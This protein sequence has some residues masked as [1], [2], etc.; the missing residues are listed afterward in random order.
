M[1]SKP[2]RIQTKKESKN[3][4]MTNWAIKTENEPINK[5]ILIIPCTFT[6]HMF[7]WNESTAYLTAIT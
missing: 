7:R 5:K 4:R 6:Y 1:I 2:I 3:L